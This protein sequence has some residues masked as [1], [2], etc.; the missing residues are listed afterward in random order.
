MFLVDVVLKKS[1]KAPGTLSNPEVSDPDF[2]RVIDDINVIARKYKLNH[3]L[4]SINRKGVP[5]IEKLQRQYLDGIQY[6]ANDRRADVTGF[7]EELKLN[8]SEVFA[9]SYKV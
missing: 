6:Q 4:N 2:K 7:L 9:Y 5:F 3:R 1:L 8:R